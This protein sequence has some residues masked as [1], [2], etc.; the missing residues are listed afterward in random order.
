MWERKIYNSETNEVMATVKLPSNK[1]CE[2]IM[3]A[4]AY[5]FGELREEAFEVEEE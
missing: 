5:E 3:A 4:G 1:E 2:W